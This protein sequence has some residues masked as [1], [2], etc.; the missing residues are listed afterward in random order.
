MIQLLIEPHTINTPTLVV[1][2]NVVIFWF[3]HSNISQQCDKSLCYH[4]NNTQPRWGSRR[5]KVL[6]CRGINCSLFVL[7]YLQKH[8]SQTQHL[9]KYDM[10]TKIYI[11]FFFT[12]FTKKIIFKYNFE[13]VP[14]FPQSL[15]LILLLLVLWLIRY[16]AFYKNRLR[17][18][19]NFYEAIVSILCGFT[20]CNL[21]SSA[22]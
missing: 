5:A 14:F 7:F 19:M 11:G 12:A 4:I 6:E 13:K 9:G 2:F 8:Q 10:E 17:S 20:S 1:F 21:S 22:Q 18:E 16:D 3:L 15:R